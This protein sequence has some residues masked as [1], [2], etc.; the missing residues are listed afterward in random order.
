MRQGRH[1]LQLTGWFVSLMLL[2]AALLPMPM[3]ADAQASNW[4]ELCTAHGI[5]KVKLP[6]GLTA[7]A[8]QKPAPD[9]SWCSIHCSNLASLLS[10]SA[11]YGLSLFIAQR[12][13][14]SQLHHYPAPSAAY[15]PAALSRAPPA[16]AG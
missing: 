8:E 15:W 5:Q 12:A 3:P 7:P 2:F 11:S 10:P 14:R 16:V 1:T 9:C 4:V 13:P 6:D